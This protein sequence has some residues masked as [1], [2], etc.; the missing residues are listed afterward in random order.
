MTW[1]IRQGKPHYCATPTG[2]F[3]DGIGRSGD[4]WRCDDCGT[5]W[6]YDGTSW[7]GWEKAGWWLRWK[8]RHQGWPEQDR[9]E[10]RR[11][12]REYDLPM[13]EETG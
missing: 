2:D 10:V 11:L 1:V 5:L 12:A 6:E 7:G 9:S 13:V 4:I 8:Y 3:G